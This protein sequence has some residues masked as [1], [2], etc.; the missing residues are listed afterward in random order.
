M[1]ISVEKL[2]SVDLLR[3]ANSFTTNKESKMSLATA[4][5][6]QHSTIRTQ[7]F[8]IEMR[9][10]P[11]FCASQFVR[12][13]VGVQWY[14]RSKRTDRGGADFRELCES[15]VEDLGNIYTAIDEGKEYEPLDILGEAR[16]IWEMPNEFDRYAP[17]DLC[18]LLSSEAIITMSLKRLCRKSS[19]ETTE[20]WKQVVEKIKDVDEDLYPHLVPRCVQCGYCP[21]KSCGFIKSQCYKIDRENYLKLYE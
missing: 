2:T 3:R 18:G 6:H 12:S 16:A 21:E 15:I 7:L 1:N 13:H 17:T 5:K 9:D 11:L 4:Y 14:Q 8:W 10:I 20:I 19:K